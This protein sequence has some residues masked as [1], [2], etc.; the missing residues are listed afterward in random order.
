VRSVLA[1]VRREI[2]AYFVSPIAYSV[3]VIFLLISGFGALRAMQMYALIPASTIEDQGMSIRGFIIGRQLTNLWVRMAM[4]LC[5]PA[6]SMRLFS[7]ER[8]GGTAELLLT[9]PLTTR[10]LVAGK[11]LGAIAVLLI[12]LALTLV[13]PGILA[14]LAIVEWPALGSAYLGIA[15][16]GATILAVG[17]FASSITE[18][19][20]VALLLTY[21]IFLP[22]MMIKMLVGAG[23][24]L[25]AAFAAVSVDFGLQRMGL[26]IIDSHFLVLYPVLSFVFLFLCVQVLDSNRWR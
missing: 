13:Y 20:I 17:V 12:L 1:I 9:S 8:K 25:D 21:A 23:T 22:F 7:E 6:L 16:F 3:I 4:V 24:G 19:Q 5:L 15:L 10:Q 2:Q 26:G 18:N 14:W 11:Y